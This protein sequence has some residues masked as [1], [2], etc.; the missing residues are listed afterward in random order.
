VHFFLESRF[1]VIDVEVLDKVNCQESHGVPV[2]ASHSSTL[3]KSK[4]R[5]P[6]HSPPFSRINMSNFRFL[7]CLVF[8]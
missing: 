5:I 1:H 2:I 6:G 3:C 4:C 7:I 8:Y